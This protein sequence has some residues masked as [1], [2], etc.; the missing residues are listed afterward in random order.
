MSKQLIPQ[1]LTEMSAELDTWMEEVACPAALL[2]SATLGPASGGSEPENSVHR[3]RRNHG[4]GHMEYQPGQGQISWTCSIVSTRALAEG[5]EWFKIPVPFDHEDGWAEV[6]IP[7]GAQSYL[8]NLIDE[9]FFFYSS[10]YLTGH[11]GKASTAGAT[12]HMGADRVWRPL[13]MQ[14]RL[15][16]SYNVLLGNT[17]GEGSYKTRCVMTAPTCRCSDRPSLCRNRCRLSALT[18]QAFT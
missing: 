9:N 7:E 13:R 12:A 3:Q 10:V 16:P 8:F 18:L 2:E 15:Y 17:V 6:E 11:S 1:V 4:L 14:A 5:E